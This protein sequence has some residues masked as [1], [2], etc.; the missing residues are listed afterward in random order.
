MSMVRI[1]TTVDGDL[2]EQARRVHGGATDTVVLEA[3][4]R[5][6][7]RELPATEADRVYADAYGRHPV[8][9]PDDWG[10][11]VAFLDAAARRNQ[12]V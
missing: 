1:S 3:A 4:L 9:E 7:L 11:L 10:D 8:D 2:L 5:A 12:S 6:L